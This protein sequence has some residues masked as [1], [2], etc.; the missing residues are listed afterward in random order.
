[1]DWVHSDP[2]T[3]FFRFPNMDY[4]CSTEPLKGHGDEKNEMGGTVVHCR[5]AL[6]LHKQILMTGPSLTIVPM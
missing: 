5:F 2:D 6:Q 1:M 3:Q 4:Q